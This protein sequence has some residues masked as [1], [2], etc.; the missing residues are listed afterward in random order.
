MD[1]QPSATITGASPLELEVAAMITSALNLEMSPSDIQPE[2]PL[3]E[4]SLG[5]DSIDIL[6][7]SL[8]V[9]KHYGVQIKADNDDNFR[10]FG[11]LRSLTAHIA[12]HRTK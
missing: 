1:S 2:D 9:S 6:E 10:I 12:E 7:L 5:L 8:V 11:S 3:Y 4:G